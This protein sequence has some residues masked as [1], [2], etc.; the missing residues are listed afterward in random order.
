MTRPLI[1]LCCFWLLLSLLSACAP[2]NPGPGTSEPVHSAANQDVLQLATMGEQALQ[3]AQ[4][5][6]PDAVLREVE[7]DLTEIT[8]H[9]T[10]PAA[11]SV[12]QIFVPDLE[13]PPET[14]RV[15]ANLISPLVGQAEP[16]IDWQRLKIGPGRVAQ[17]LTGHWPGC[18][19][20]SLILYREQGTLTWVAF[21]TIPEGLVSGNMNAETGVFQPSQAPPASFPVTATPE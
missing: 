5:Q 19:V 20:H 12:T 4:A 11:T 1:R 18:E 14:W 10:D 15:E 7:T 6:T 9:F 3:L 21:C 16:G 13:S 17:A 2:L 8:F